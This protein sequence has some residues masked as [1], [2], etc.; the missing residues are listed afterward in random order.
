MVNKVIL[1]G[2]VGAEP[3]VRALETG[4]KMAK[5]RVATTERIYNA[6]TGE[7]R[8]HTDWHTVV[9]W[10]GQA[11]FA[12]RYIRKGAQIYVEGKIRSREWMEEATGNKR[13]AVEILSEEVRLLGGGRRNEGALGDDRRQEARKGGVEEGVPELSKDASDLP[14]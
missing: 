6:A 9:L 14:F 2:Y 12:E 4:N 11:D 7:K 1:I 13:Y 5:L 8:E 10:R 3:E